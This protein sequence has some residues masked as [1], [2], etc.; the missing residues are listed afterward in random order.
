MEI[1]NLKM[2][3]PQ[4][5][6]SNLAEKIVAQSTRAL[7]EKISLLEAQIEKF[8]TK[9]IGYIDYCSYPGCGAWDVAAYR[10]GHRGLPYCDGCDETFCEIH[11]W[12]KGQCRRCCH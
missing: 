11:M 12:I 1:L 8:N 7:E 4:R 10:N 5:F 3:V 9:E 2:S 6:A